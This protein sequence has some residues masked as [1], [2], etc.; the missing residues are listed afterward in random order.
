LHKRC[1]HTTEVYAAP[2]RQAVNTHQ[3]YA[4]AA[5]NVQ[6]EAVNTEQDAVDA[7]GGWYRSQSGL[8]PHEEPWTSYDNG[9]N[10]TTK[11][12]LC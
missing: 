1:K 7:K 8:S 12:A 10:N 11:L 5:N 9:A 2:V 6:W 4:L 3:D